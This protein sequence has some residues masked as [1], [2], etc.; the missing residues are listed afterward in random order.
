MRFAISTALAAALALIIVPAA[1]A[2]QLTFCNDA[3]A[4]GFDPA[5]YTAGA[6]LDASS[7]AFYDRLVEFAPGSTA[8]VPGLATSWDV[9]PDGKQYTFHLRDGVAFAAGIGFAPTRPLNADDVVF[10]LTRQ[11]DPKNPYFSYAGGTWPYYSA[12]G[13]NV[14]VKSVVKVDAA[15]VRITLTRPD[16]SILGDLAMDFASI[17]SKEYA[18]SLIK[19]KTPDLLNTVPV[20]TGPFI[21]SRND[22]GR[23][24]TVANLGYWDGAPKIDGVT[25]LPVAD[26]AERLA[27]LKSGA[28]DVAAE[29][30]AATLKEAQSD[31]DLTLAT[32]ERADVVTLAFN[33]TVPPFNDPRVRQALGQ[34]IDRQAIV[35]AVYGGTASPAKALLPSTMAGTNGEAAADE[36]YDVDGAKQLL[37]AA[38][39]SNLK[40]KLLATKAPRPY[41][42][43][44]AATATLIAADFAKVGVDATVELPDTLGEYLRQSSDKK[45]DGAVLIG[46]TSDN[47]DAASFLALLL[48]CD[49]V[50]KS[51]R[52]QWC[53]ADFDKAITAARA[54]TDP[55][56]EFAG[57]NEA[58]TIAA[59]E[60][61]LT[62]LVHTLSIV[63]M[64]KAV[65]G[66]VA[67]P[68]GRHNFAK[69]DISP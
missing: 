18:D 48:S 33:T 1:Q 67:D 5:L 49:A 22:G 14:L 15:T 32:A 24:V 58:Q 51:N 30:D 20:G 65:S 56:A 40:L 43:D 59:R 9:S 63:P 31:P 21:F 25:F 38:G 34:A 12:L 50:G 61:P 41:S 69:A 66:V 68:L 36:T 6:T 10:S 52:A 4:E 17:L 57:L 47:G 27:R 8:I 11:F 13:L 35:D 42:P 45:R 26:P 54:A 23:V 3:P 62:A 64:R 44:L 2:K 60:V 39:V 7:Q 29:P 28:C 53:D 19:A 55:M 37:A 16:P 46:W